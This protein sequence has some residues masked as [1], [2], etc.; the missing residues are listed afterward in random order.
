MSTWHN[1]RETWSTA[2]DYDIE[3]V[4]H[5]RLPDWGLTRLGRRIAARQLTERNASVDEISA[6]I[7]V[8]P[9]TVYRWRAEDRQAAA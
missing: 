9:R 5:D 1:R 4:V 6:L 2:D 7:G 3:L 8:D